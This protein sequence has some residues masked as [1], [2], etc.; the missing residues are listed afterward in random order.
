MTINGCGYQPKSFCE[1]FL[2]HFLQ[3]K[4]VMIFLQKAH[5]TLPKRKSLSFEAF[6]QD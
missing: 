5:T 1:H 3:I 6:Q 4:K 2:N